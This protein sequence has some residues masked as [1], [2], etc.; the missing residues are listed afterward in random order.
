M[1]GPDG[2]VAAGGRVAGVRERLNPDRRGL[3]HL[4]RRSTSA[5]AGLTRRSCGSTGTAGSDAWIGTGDDALMEATAVLAELAQQFRI[6]ELV[7]DPWR[8]QTLAKIA[9]AARHQV[10][11]FPQSDSRMLP[12]SAALHQAIKERRIH[13]P[14]DP[15]LNEHV[16]AAVAR[17]GRRG[18]ADRPG[19]ARG[20]HRRADRAL[21]GA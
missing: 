1:G 21:H 11:A 17:H 20:E 19:A 10:T 5:A 7:F 13:H 18:L 12:A 8:A 2:L 15:K 9:E 3:G 16:A 4:G 14:N 6:R